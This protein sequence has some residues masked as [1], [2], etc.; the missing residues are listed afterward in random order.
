MSHEEEESLGREPGDGGHWEPRIPLWRTEFPQA[1]TSD[2][3]TSARY[4]FTD[5]PIAFHLVLQSDFY[6]SLC[7]DILPS[8][9]SLHNK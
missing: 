6:S 9:K 8:A 3:D 2:T 1:D 4:K 5:A 7:L